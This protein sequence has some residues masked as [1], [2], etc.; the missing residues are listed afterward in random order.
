MKNLSQMLLILSVA[1]T[2]ACIGLSGAVGADPL[3]GADYHSS[4]GRPRQPSFGEPEADNVQRVAVGRSVRFKC[5]VNDI[6][7]HKV[8]SGTFLRPPA[9]L[10]C[11]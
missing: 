3:L 10:Y 8:S 4:P 9:P 7:D 6:G 5:A 2:C 1:S 11:A